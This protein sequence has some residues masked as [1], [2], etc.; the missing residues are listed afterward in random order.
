MRGL[1]GDARVLDLARVRVAS[2]PLATAAGSS[3]IAAQNTSYSGNIP[4]PRTNASTTGQQSE[5]VGPGV[6]PV[7]L[8]VRI[9]AVAV[10]RDLHRRDEG[11]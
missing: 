2:Q 7:G 3:R 9:A 4:A 1:G 6:H 11:M 5:A 8:P 10:E